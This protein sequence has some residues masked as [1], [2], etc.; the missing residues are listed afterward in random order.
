MIHERFFRQILPRL[1]LCAV[2]GPQIACQ[3][4]DRAPWFVGKSEEA[5]N[6]A[7]ICRSMEHIN[8]T[9][10]VLAAKGGEVI[11]AGVL[12]DPENANG[13]DANTLLEIASA[14]KQITGAAAAY[15]HEHGKL[16]L[17]API[18]KYLKGVPESC[19]AITVRNLLQH[20]SGIP[21]RVIEGGHGTLQQAIDAFLGGGPKHEPGTHWEYWNQGYALT[22]AIIEQ[23]SGKTFQK[24][25]RDYL[26]RPAGM[27]TACFTG[28]P[29]PR[30]AHQATG[31]GAAAARKALDHPY[32]NKYSW[33][34]K[35]M[36]GAVMSVWD[37]WHWDRALHTDKPLGEA[38]KAQLF[39]VG[40]DDYALGWRVTNNGR[41]THKHSGSVR[42]FNCDVRRYP[43]D[44][45]FLVVLC[46]R[47]DRNA[48]RIITQCEAALFGDAFTMP[49]RPLS[50]E[51][52]EAIVGSYE[53]KG[54]LKVE[55]EADGRQTKAFICWGG[56][57]PRFST[58][59]IGWT[60]DSKLVLYEWNS[61]SSMT[62]TKKDGKVD[63]TLGRSKLV[64][65]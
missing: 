51:D 58:T 33:Q 62:M 28:D 43:D 16:D 17:D 36:G 14:T 38:G 5:Q 52:Q 8:A 37:L 44:D 9:G 56:H 12:G 6:I 47:D 35:G 19:K 40:L 24:F 10:T 61:Q 63:L 30:G 59:Y 41:L 1:A 7:A 27:K 55:I 21:G 50:K 2:L 4:P 31:T 45:A 42:G 22:A 18:S 48:G 65:K 3:A 11:F 46:N 32:G 53:D 60:P 57:R 25:C 34:Y 20:T 54:G 13:M 26:F 23:V 64:R 15:L 29:L 49:P 39:S